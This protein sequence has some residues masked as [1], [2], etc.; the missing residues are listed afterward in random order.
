MWLWLKSATHYGAN[1]CN[2]K[3]KIHTLWILMGTLS[4]I[5]EKGK[6]SS[7]DRAGTDHVRDGNHPDH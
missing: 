1:P 3:T 4:E 5:S 6:R 2:F 7:S